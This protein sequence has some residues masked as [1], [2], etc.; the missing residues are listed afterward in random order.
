VVVIVWLQLPMQYVPI[1]T[2]YAICAYH[3]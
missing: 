2:T 3:H 1:T